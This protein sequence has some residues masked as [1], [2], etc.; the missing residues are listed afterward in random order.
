MKPIIGILTS[1]KTNEVEGPYADYYMVNKVYID[2]I[3]EV[4]GIPLGIIEVTDEVLDKC[5]GFL[6]TGGH[7]ITEDHYKI[8]EY[9]IKKSKPLLGVCNGMQAIVLYAR[10]YEECVNS[11][12]DPTPTNLYN[13]YGELRE[14]GNYILERL[15]G[16]GGELSRREIPV[17]MEN[18]NKFKHDVNIKEGTVLFDI[19]KKP[20]INVFSIHT[21][22][23]H[24]VTNTLEI[25][26]VS[27]DNVV[28]AIKYKDKPIIGVQFHIDLDETS[29]LFE[30]F[31]EKCKN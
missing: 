24:D 25:M 17:Y 23:Y 1:I 26:G 18:I 16:H 21:Y 7:R 20:K 6:L 11:N 15:E 2:K 9:C 3:N 8:I 4:G 14:K 27:D 5:S 28:E 13:K 12:I 22:G 29:E 30:R 19:Y 10:L 31:I